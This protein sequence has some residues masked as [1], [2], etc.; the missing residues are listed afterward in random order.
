MIVCKICHRPLS[1]PNSVY[2]EIGPVC[3]RKLRLRNIAKQNNMELPFDKDYSNII[4]NPKTAEDK[5]GNIYSIKSNH[6]KS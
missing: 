5:N 3:K 1:N 4:L 6:V 2:Y